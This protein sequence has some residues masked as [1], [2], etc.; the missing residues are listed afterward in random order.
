MPIDA[1]IHPPDGTG[2]IPLILVVLLHITKTIIMQ[3]VEYQSDIAER[4]DNEY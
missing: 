1:H 3:L 4:I 2:T